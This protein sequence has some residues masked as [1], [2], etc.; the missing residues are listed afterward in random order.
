MHPP[1]KIQSNK[2]FQTLRRQRLLRWR[3]TLSKICKCVELLS[4]KFTNTVTD[5]QYFDLISLPIDAYP[6]RGSVPETLSIC[7]SS[8]LITETFTGT[9]TTPRA[10]KSPFPPPGQRHPSCMCFLASCV[11]ERL[12]C[13]SMLFNK[14][15]S[16]EGYWGRSKR[17]HGK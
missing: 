10:I 1:P 4:P 12:C 8:K 17:G 6:L 14:N 16:K 3:L 7:N 13:T 9:Q 2:K 15:S 11:S 5:P